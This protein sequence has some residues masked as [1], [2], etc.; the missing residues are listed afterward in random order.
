MYKKQDPP[1]CLQKT[2]NGKMEIKNVGPN[3]EVWNFVTSPAVAS[4]ESESSREIQIDYSPKWQCFV[5]ASTWGTHHFSSRK[6]SFCAHISNT[7]Y[8]HALYL[9]TSPTTVT[10]YR[11]KNQHL[12]LAAPEF[13]DLLLRDQTL[14]CLL[15]LEKSLL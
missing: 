8:W 11:I 7:I 6:T 3:S 14:L 9:S 15:L 2:I 1:S 10:W 4:T 13:F 5:H 12:L